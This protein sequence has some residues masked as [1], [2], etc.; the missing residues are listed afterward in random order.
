LLPF[1]LTAQQKISKK[2]KKREKSGTIPF[3]EPAS[4][5]YAEPGACCPL[6]FSV[7]TKGIPLKS[8]KH[9]ELGGD[10]KR[11]GQMIQF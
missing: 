1:Y 2:K 3:T 9:F 8:C 6:P 7:I 4:G 11:K 5:P 10:K